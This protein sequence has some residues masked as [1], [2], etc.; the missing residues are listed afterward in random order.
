MLEFLSLKTEPFGM[1]ITDSSV[2]IIDLKEKRGKIFCT[3]IGYSKIEPGVIKG[4][5]IKNGAGL[6]E[7]IKTA[8]KK[9]RG[10]KLKKKSV[11]LSIPEDKAFLQ[12]IQ[13]PKIKEENLKSA[14]IFEAE[15]YIPLP[16][17][18]VYLD[19]QIIPSTEKIDHLDILIAAFPKDIIDSYVQVMADAGLRPFALELESQ[20]AARALVKDYSD[21]PVLIVHIGDSK[22]NLIIHAGYSLRFSFSIPIS[23]NYFLE[24]ISRDLAVDAAAAEELKAKYGIEKYSGKGGLIAAENKG[25]DEKEERKI[26]EALI[27]GLVDFVQQVGKYLNYYQT[28]ASHE[29]LP[30]NKRAVSKMIF[31]GSG[32]N[33]KGLDKLVS[34]K[35]NLPVEIWKT[36]IDLSGGGNPKEKAASGQG[37]DYVIALGLA[38]RGM[39]ESRVKEIMKK[40]SKPTNKQAEKTTPL[41]RKL[42]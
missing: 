30:K 10:G 35:F 21:S 34:L 4:G 24:M 5:E 27:P 16:L 23:N 38:Q 2:R 39:A 41:G 25:S 18:K 14:V 1:E 36:D 11:V 31:C 17:E 12:V 22:T 29:H 26:F 15:N 40:E 13:M 28:H 9:C 37:N 33:L 8:I 19:Y 6:S 42:G 3:S 7:I 20:A 32:A